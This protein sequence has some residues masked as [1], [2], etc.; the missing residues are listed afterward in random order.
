M[1]RFLT[2]PSPAHSLIA[3]LNG[4]LNPQSNC[5]L[6][7]AIPPE[8]RH[9][10]FSFALHSYDDASRPY[11]EYSYY[12]RP[13]YRY[14][15]RINTNLLATC[16]RIYTETHDLAVS[17]NEHVFWCSST[18]GPPR[19]FFDNPKWY[20]S[21]FTVEQRAAVVYIH[22]FTQLYWLERSE[23]FRFFCELEDI[24]PLHLKITVRHTDWWFWELNTP[25]VMKYH[26][27]GTFESMKKLEILDIEL[28]SI[29][30]DL[31]QVFIF[32]L[33]IAHNTDSD[34]FILLLDEHHCQE[35]G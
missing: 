9:R 15:Q 28:E 7:G 10:I 11:P 16:R 25:L 34:L 17:L 18:R 6:F 22:L 12:S 20:F 32:I 14:H 24:H 13:G 19:D 30:R 27:A 4:P 1:T 8:I 26:W 29:E 33:N 23:S 3:T 31:D 35:H 21:K 5:F 2:P